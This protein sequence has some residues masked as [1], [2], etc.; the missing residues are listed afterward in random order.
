M[1]ITI[2]NS[3]TIFQGDIFDV[4]IDSIRQD[5]LEYDRDIVIH[6]GSAVIVP[7]FDDLTVAL[8]RQY[9]H[10]AGQYLLELPAGTLEKGETPEEAAI[11][12]LEE[13][14]GWRAGKIEKL[15]SFF[16]S[17]GFLSE[18][19]HLFIAQNLTESI[20]NLDED[21]ALTFERLPLTNAILMAAS[22][23]LRDAKTIA[24]LFLA[25]KKLEI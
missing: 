22:G 5:D 3:R 2:K 6:P 4:R 18:E 8:V 23:Q 13:E 9:R 12:E 10:A 14:I 24:G 16:V 11:R 21:E 17:P 7:L 1:N 25:A 20:Q 19:M 15:S